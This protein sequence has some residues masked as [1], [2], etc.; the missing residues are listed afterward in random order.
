V[1]THLPEDRWVQAIEVQ[2]GDRN[3]VHA[4]AEERGGFWGEYVPGQNTLVFPAGT[5]EARPAAT[6]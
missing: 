4:A 2:P 6:R 3:V 5:C 1:E